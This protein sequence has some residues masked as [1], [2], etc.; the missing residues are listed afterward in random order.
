M[1]FGYWSEKLLAIDHIGKV[2]YKKKK[3]TKTINL[4]AYPLKDFSNLFLDYL[5]VL[6]L[7]FD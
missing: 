2:T 3:D 6:A 7:F 1:K 4:Q 5:G